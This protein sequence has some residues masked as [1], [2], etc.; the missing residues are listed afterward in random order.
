M[1]VQRTNKYLQMISDIYM[2]YQAYTLN[3]Y[4][5]NIFILKYNEFIDVTILY[6]L[7]IYIYIYILHFYVLLLHEDIKYILKN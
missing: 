2:S 5:V 1:K 6:L 3:I 4:I 7:Y